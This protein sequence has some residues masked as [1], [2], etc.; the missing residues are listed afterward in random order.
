MRPT[1][2]IYPGYRGGTGFVQ[3]LSSYREDLRWWE[4][5]VVERDNTLQLDIERHVS[6]NRHLDLFPYRYSAMA[7]ASYPRSTILR[8]ALHLPSGPTREQFEG[9][10]SNLSGF[11][12]DERI[13]RQQASL[14]YRNFSLGILVDWNVEHYRP[15][16]SVAAVHFETVPTLDELLKKIF[17]HIVSLFNEIN[18]TRKLDSVVVN[19]IIDLAKQRDAIIPQCRV[20]LSER[21]Y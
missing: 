10:V 7:S 11:V 13:S 2:V 14:W 20:P 16:V 15:Y 21:H 1:E 3:N 12:V 6:W 18:P 9:M 19:K 17:P 8:E 4:P 5:E